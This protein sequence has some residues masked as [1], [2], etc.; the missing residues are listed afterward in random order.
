MAGVYGNLLKGLAALAALLLGVTALAITLDVIARN[1]GLGTL[2]WILE[3]SE[4]VLPLATFLAAPW[5]LRRNEHVRLDVLLTAFPR[6]G[7]LANLVGLA[8][9]GVL[10]VYGVR[11]ILN[12]AAQGSMV[13]KSVVFPEWWLYAPVPLCFGLLS[14]EFLRRLAG[15]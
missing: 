9:C 10:V 12:S 2:P 4:Y 14:I 8:V 3:V 6:L 13:F 1:V 11:T 7:V 5:L 15:R